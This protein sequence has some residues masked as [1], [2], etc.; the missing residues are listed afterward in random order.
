MNYFKWNTL[1][2]IL[3]VS[4][5]LYSIPAFA[6]GTYIGEVCWEIEG[7]GDEEPS[8]GTDYVKLAV[9]DIGAGHLTLNGY[10]FSSD[11]ESVNERTLLNGNAEVFGDQIFFQLNGLSSEPDGLFSLSV[12]TVLSL[13]TLNGTV[14]IIGSGFDKNTQESGILADSGTVTIT[15]CP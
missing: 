2:T 6:D 15:T 14:E 4:S 12:R 1:L 9:F 8:E 5:G 11:D 7:L 13:S 3:L 10:S